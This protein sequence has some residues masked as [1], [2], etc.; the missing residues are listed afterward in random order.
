MKNSRKSKYEMRVN[1]N[2]R[3]HRCCLCVMCDVFP[4]QMPK[5]V[6][7][8]IVP[9]KLEFHKVFGFDFG[10][11]EFTIREQ[12]EVLAGHNDGDEDGCGNIKPKSHKVIGQ[13]LMD[14]ADEQEQLL[15]KF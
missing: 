9:D 5:S 11:T 6:K 2:D 4:E 1:K 12:S 14:Y 7:S 15:K 8:T 13:A 10:D 3:N